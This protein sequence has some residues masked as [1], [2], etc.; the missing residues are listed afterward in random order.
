MSDQ[1][2][3]YSNLIVT[4]HYGRWAGVTLAALSDTALPANW[5]YLM[6]EAELLAALERDHLRLVPGSLERYRRD[7][8]L[9]PGW[10]AF[11]VEAE[12]TGLPVDE[13]LPTRAWPARLR[14]AYRALSDLWDAIAHDR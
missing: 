10:V 9:N 12:A 3:T 5:H 4:R 11:V 14:S 2:E 1:T 6:L 13:R 7:D 8:V